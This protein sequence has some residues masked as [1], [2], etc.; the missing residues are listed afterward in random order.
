MSESV[1]FPA[2]KTARVSRPFR[3]VDLQMYGATG[4]Y[5]MGVD[6]VAPLAS[7]IFAAAKG[8]V[9]EAGYKQKGGYGRRV[10]LQHDG[11]E[12]LY[13]HLHTVLVEVGEEVEAGAQ[14]GTMGG[15]V[16]DPYRGASGGTHLHFEVILP[17]APG[18]LETVRTYHGWCVDPLPWLANHFLPRARWHA[19]VTVADGVKVRVAPSVEATA[20]GALAYRFRVDVLEQTRDNAGNLWCRLRS[21]RPEWSAATYNR[22]ELLRCEEAEDAPDA[23]DEAADLMDDDALDARLE[24]IAARLLDTEQWLKEQREWIEQQREALSGG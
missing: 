16:E 9:I 22:A 4:G 21:I 1:R 12:T 20:V 7:P 5:H 8:V 6:L 10:V 14:I 13:A 3:Y 2:V 11:F 17:E 24:E 23:S 19:K 18:G 15:N